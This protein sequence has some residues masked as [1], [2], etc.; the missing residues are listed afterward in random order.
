MSEDPEIARIMQ[1][2][3]QEML[4]GRDASQKEPIH[5]A[6]HVVH[7]TSVVDLDPLAFQ[8]TISEPNPTL[9][10]FWAEWCGPCKAMHP[11]FENLNTMYPNIRFARINVDTCP[12]IATQLGIQS[13]PTFIMFQA[14]AVVD[15]MMGAVGAEG[16]H[17]ICKK[18]T[19]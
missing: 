11:I 5:D 17:A 3:L 19:A 4:R 6:S 12:Q 8:K 2:K 18:Y 7:A 13:I 9:V 14:G 1:R 10:D 16:I 15:R